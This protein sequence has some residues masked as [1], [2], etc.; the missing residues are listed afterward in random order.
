MLLR[1]CA[2]FALPIATFAALPSVA[3]AQQIT[4][5]I[6]GTVTSEAGQPLAGARVAVT[7]TRT[8][9]TVD[10]TADAE[11]RFSAQNLTTGGPYTVTA[12]A[13]G[14][15]GQT[16]QDIQI[17]LQGNTQ[18]TFSLAPA[19]AAATGEQ[20]ITVTGARARVRQLETG[21][22]TSFGAAVLETAPT[23]NRDIRDVIRLDPRVSLER[24]DLSGQDRISC[25]GGNDRGNA[26]TVDGIAQSDIYGLN[27]NGFSARSSTPLP[28]DAIRETQVQFAPFDVEYGQFTGCAVN[29][30][31]RGGTNR[32]RAAGFYEYTGADLTGKR[33]GGLRFD[34]PQKDEQFGVSLGGPIIKDRLFVFGAYEKR[35]SAD[36]EDRG[37]VGS[38]AAIQVTGISLAQFNE[39]S[40][41]LRTQ[42]G[43]DTG[44]LATDLPFENERYFLRGDLVLG[45]HRVE[46][47]YQ[48]LDEGRVSSDD[49]FT[50]NSPQVTGFNTYST[51]GSRSDFYSGRLYSQWTDRLSTELR[52]SR[53][54]ITDK[55]DPIGGGEAQS[56]NP[57]PRIIVGID[58][59]TGID[60]TVLAGPG[61][62][63]SANDLRTQVD[64][65]K[66]AA[67]FNA[68]RHQFKA[69]I[70][71]NEAD[72]FNLFVQNATGTLVFRNVADLRLGRLSPGTGNN[73]T[74]TTPVN[75][76][77]GATEGAFGNF[78]PG[79][80]VETAAA[81]F[82]RTLYSIYAQ[83]E[84]SVNDAVNVTA[85][86]RYDWYDGEGP[87]PNPNFIN[88]FGVT[89][90]TGFND[91]DGVILPRVAVNWR[92][93][94]FGPFAQTRVRTG[95]GIFSGGDPLVWFGNAFQ[96][97]GSTFGLANTQAA[98]CPTGQISVLN[99]AGQFTGVPQC[100]I[101]AAGNLAA[102]GQGNTQS[103]DPDI[104]L[105]TVTRFNIGFETVLNGGGSGFFSNWRVAGDYILSRY[106]NPF[107]IVDLA[108]AIN[109][110]RGLNGFTIDGRPIYSAIDLSAAGCTG[111]LVDVGSPP[112]FT[113]LNAACFTGNRQQEYA[114]TNAR[115]YTSQIASLLISKNFNRGII[116]DGGNVFVNFG[117][118]FGNAKDRRN[119]YNSTANSNFNITAAFDRNNPDVSEGFYN[120]RHQ[121]SLSTSFTERFFGDLASRLSATFTARAGRPYS[122]TFTGGAGVFNTNTGGSSNDN[123]LLYVPSGP[124]DPNIAPTSNAAAVQSLLD[125]TSNLDCA[126]DYRGRTIER[127]TCR[128]DWF[129]D[130]DL[131][132]SQ[133]LPGPGRLIGRDDRIEVYGM[134]DNFLNLLDQD[135]NVQR[136][137]NFAGLQDVARVTGIDSQG[138]YII[139]QF[140][141]DSFE[142]DNIVRPSQ[143][144]WRM[145]VG[146]SYRF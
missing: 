38:D 80:Q 102:A 74:S 24:D 95:V 134:I 105:P 66:F 45:D 34:P 12:T 35:E 114:L 59:P 132:F 78:T 106:N 56:D 33:A 75:V 70:E 139:S 65:F 69:G 50:G 127:N 116:T 53:S 52:Y 142:S 76:V 110:A 86:I 100:V 136:R 112:V 118:A 120:T 133:E 99:A 130:L 109:P 77:S 146:V 82:T 88:R 67:R 47:T 46:A 143:S 101:T 62:S 144:L 115:G 79:N 92:L 8:G 122:L 19:A 21:P 57:V 4:S 81:Q 73:Q 94:D 37:P 44:P 29:V 14:F 93:G 40:D 23:F 135:W 108:Q 85:G 7:D 124:N 43:V 10:L 11:G 28:Y 2:A 31:T 30:V 96:N 13:D 90:A 91:I 129:Y 98:G 26:F 68:G 131:R 63:R 39:I 22:G 71:M 117:Y 17:T 137:R 126:R 6:T 58:N 111:D 20:T 103:V 49:F 55:Q 119:L 89:N 9:Q 87:S 5:G 61:N 1:T 84:W 83:D 140:T 107:N 72:I 128:N 3:A 141:G 64:Q 25:L 97:D 138:R 113:N 48:R 32:I 121:V 51:S 41:V 54:K 18:L 104:K 27:D 16:V 60:G 15:Q 125:F 123:A 145:K 42:Y 36:T